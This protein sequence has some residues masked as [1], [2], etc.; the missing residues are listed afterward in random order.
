[1]GR[2]ALGNPGLAPGPGRV[3]GCTGSLPGWGSAPVHGHGG[4]W[5][6]PGGGQSPRAPTGEH[7]G[8][9]LQ[10]GALEEQRCKS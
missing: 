5:Y 6:R 2:V 1:M 7:S 10:Q 9:W 8:L 4:V 3:G